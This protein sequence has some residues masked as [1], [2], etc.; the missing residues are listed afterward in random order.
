MLQDKNTVDLG[1]VDSPMSIPDNCIILANGKVIRH[2]SFKKPLLTNAIRI[3]YTVQMGLQDERSPLGPAGIHGMCENSRRDLYMRLIED[4]MADPLRCTKFWFHPL[5]VEDL[6]DSLDGGEW[7]L[8]Y[9]SSPPLPVSLECF[10]TSCPNEEG[11]DW[12]TK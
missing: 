6:G 7:P 3:M 1:Y 12:W 8:R 4:R 2:P 9:D 10:P 11:I 5:T